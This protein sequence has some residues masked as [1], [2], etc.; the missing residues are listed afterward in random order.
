M[1]RSLRGTYPDVGSIQTDKIISMM[2]AVARRKKALNL[3]A[4]DQRGPL[5]WFENMFLQLKLA[6]HYHAFIHAYRL[7][8]GTPWRFAHHYK[9]S[10]RQGA[11][12]VYR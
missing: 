6:F 7:A 10:H 2:S 3:T 12:H 1:E 4:Q 5:E 9:L 8:G 11:V